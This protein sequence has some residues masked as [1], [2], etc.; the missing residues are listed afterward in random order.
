M[1][2][3]YGIFDIYAPA[4]PT[5]GHSHVVVIGPSWFRRDIFL[6][7]KQFARKGNKW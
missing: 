5:L 4:N 1:F 2:D 3:I 7:N 6:G